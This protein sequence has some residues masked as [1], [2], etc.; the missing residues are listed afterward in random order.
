[1]DQEN[2]I[3]VT[4]RS[5]L[6]PDEPIAGFRL[7]ESSPMN[8]PGGITLGGLTRRIYHKKSDQIGVMAVNGKLAS[9]E[10]MLLPGDSIDVYPLLEGG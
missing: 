6:A 5:F 10:T 2:S 3:T 4:I 7:G 8:V 1:M 9:E